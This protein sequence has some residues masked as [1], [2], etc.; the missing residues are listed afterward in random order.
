MAKIVSI[1]EH[2]AH[3]LNDLKDS[4]WGDLEARTKLSW[5]RLFESESE[6]LR[7]L[8]T[9]CDSYDRGPRP[10][11]SYRNGYTRAGSVPVL[12]CGRKARSRWRGLKE[13]LYP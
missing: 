10:A 9:A 8:Y 3:F 4:F 7:R 5:K 6:R 2:F 1:T 11:G 12:G 13:N